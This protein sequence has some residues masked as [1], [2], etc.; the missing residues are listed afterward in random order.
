MSYQDLVTA[1]IQQIKKADFF[2][3]E[4]KLWT[5][6][7]QY[8]KSLFDAKK[9]LILALN[10]KVEWMWPQCF[11]THSFEDLQHRVTA[12]QTYTLFRGDSQGLWLRR[13]CYYWCCCRNEQKNVIFQK[14]FIFNM[15]ACVCVLCVFVVSVGGC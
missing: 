8:L 12:F 6:L 14:L 3:F 4:E 15:F 7:C 2:A 1:N 10:V 5:S 13:G 9:W 11:S